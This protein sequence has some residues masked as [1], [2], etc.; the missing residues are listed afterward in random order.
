MKFCQNCGTQFGK[1][2]LKIPGADDNVIL[3]VRP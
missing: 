2:V 3:L 1:G